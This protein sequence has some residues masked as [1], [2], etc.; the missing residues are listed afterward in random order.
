MTFSK[1]KNRIKLGYLLKDIKTLIA[2]ADWDAEIVKQKQMY[3]DGYYITPDVQESVKQ[4]NDMYDEAESGNFGG[5][6][7][8]KRFTKFR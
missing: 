1:R 4:A 2:G 5:N 7:T 6:K 8:Y 3:L